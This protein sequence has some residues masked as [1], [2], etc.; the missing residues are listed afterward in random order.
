V[1]V[2]EPCRLLKTRSG[3]LVSVHKIPFREVTPTER[4][5]GPSTGGIKKGRFQSSLESPCLFNLLVVRN[6]LT[7]F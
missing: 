1:L 7:L 2:I 6:A 3:M 5:P 4:S